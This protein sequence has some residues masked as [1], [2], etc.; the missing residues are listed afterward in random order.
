MPLRS[1]FALITCIG[2]LCSAP[3]WAE[4]IRLVQD[5]AYAPYMTKD[6]KQPTGI[7]AEVITQA[8]SRIEGDYDVVLDAVPWSRAVNLVESGQAHGLVGTYYKPD[9]RPWIGTYSTAPFTENVAVYCRDGVA[10]AG[11]SYPQDFKGLTFGN[12]AG[13]G[14]PGQAFFDLVASGLISLQEAPTTDLNL[15][16]LAAGRIDCYVQEQLTAEI[17]ITALGISGITQVLDTSVED[18]MIG[19]RASWQGAE[20]EGFIA[21]MDRVLAEMMADGTIDQIIA[22]AVAG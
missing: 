18:S 4:T 14:T 17:A 11:W 12:N 6:G 15:K 20:A 16:K 7:W 19:F 13:F 1:F 8:L 3:V 22:T 5:E 2:T 21:E 10:E 9:S